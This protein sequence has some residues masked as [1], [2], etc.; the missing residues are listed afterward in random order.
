MLCI[1]DKAQLKSPFPP[2]SVRQLE[3]ALDSTFVI[4]FSCPLQRC[5]KICHIDHEGKV[6]FQY[7]QGSYSKFTMLSQESFMV[8]LENQ[9]FFVD[10][11]L[12]SKKI[13]KMDFNL[14]SNE[15][16]SLSRTFV[17]SNTNFICFVEEKSKNVNDDYNRKSIIA[18]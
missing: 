11:N 8:R 13:T 7:F 4:L 12:K 10:V 1:Q 6:I 5:D 2:A 17:F 18:K 3:I 14:A 9:A 15:G 16:F